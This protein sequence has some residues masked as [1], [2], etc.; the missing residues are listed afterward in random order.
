MSGGALIAILAD[1]LVMD[2][3]AVLGPVDPQLGSAQSAF[4]A[5]SIVRA[6]AQPNPNRDDQTLILGDVAEKALHQV[7]MTVKRLLLEH[8]P[9]PMPSGSPRSSPRASGHTTTRSTSPGSAS[10]GLRSQRTCPVRSTTSWIS[11]RRRASADR[12]WS[13]SRSRTPPRRLRCVL[14]AIAPQV[15]R[16]S[17]FVPVRASTERNATAHRSPRRPRS[18]SRRRSGPRR[19]PQ[20]R[21]AV[22]L[23]RPQR[24]P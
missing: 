11:S 23:R 5:A 16:A 17:P 10:S 6:L 3:N 7:R 9:R 1:E 4:P 21:S 22:R 12:A 18:R 19:V 15:S 8:M 20:R 2:P 24:I 14:G 13:S